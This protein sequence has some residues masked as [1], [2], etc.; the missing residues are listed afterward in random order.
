M[1]SYFYE[2]TGNR[3][4][5]VPLWELDLYQNRQPIDYQIVS[6]FL[7]QLPGKDLVDSMLVLSGHPSSKN[8]HMDVFEPRGVSP[9]GQTGTWSTMCGNGIRAIGQFLDEHFQLFSR[10]NTLEIH[11]RSGLL[12]LKKERP[13]YFSIHMGKATFRK[14][15]LRR[16][17]SEEL[18]AQSSSTLTDI[19]LTGYAELGRWTLGFTC[20][21]DIVEKDGEPHLVQ[22]ISAGTSLERLQFLAGSLGARLIRERLLF[23]RE[24]NL[25]LYAI[26]NIDSA[27][28]CVD[29]NLC[30]FERGIYYVTASC[31]TGSTMTAA[32]IF[33]QKEFHHY[34]QVNI[35]TIG[36]QITVRRDLRDHLTM[37]GVAKNLSRNDMVFTRD[38]IEEISPKAVL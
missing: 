35:L 4:M 7:L 22:A 36:G 29:I 33:R 23:P 2:A 32:T 19:L 10:D 25:N 6:L 21:P 3:F 34:K 1:N 17:I 15:D 37:S 38:K 26:S 28:K 14:E 20:N 27:N 9:D 11:T 24:V 30:T 5:I 16:Y 18:F 12:A 13:G 8:I 31:G